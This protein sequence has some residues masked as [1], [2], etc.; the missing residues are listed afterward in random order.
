M[1]TN[2]KTRFRLALATLLLAPAVSY[3]QDVDIA[4][5]PALWVVESNDSRVYL[6]GS[7]HLLPP[8]VYPLPET[9]EAAYLR[10][11]AVAFEIDLSAANEMAMTMMQRGLFTDATTLADA[12]GAELAEEATAILMPMG[13]PGEA[14]ERMRPWMVA[15]IVGTSVAQLEGMEVAAGL[16]MHF[17]ERAGHDGKI[18]TS[19][20]TAESQIDIFA[21]MDE[22]AQAEYL[23]QAVDQMPE[24]GEKLRHMVAAW[25]IGDTEVLQALVQ[26]GMEQYP[27]LRTRLLEDRN[28]AWVPQ[29][30]AMLAEPGR[31]TLVVVG[32]A[33][34][35]GPHSVVEL[36]EEAGYEVR[37]L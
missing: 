15:M 19:F 1:S 12:V 14:V 26:E 9:V 32:A 21:S 23:R 28:R 31:T 33:H 27:A 10:S 25:R 7:V 29:I 11:D 34:L 4:T 16:D 8:D 6:L 22:Q 24:A 20:E 13:I 30:E 2:I 37:R 35:I 36:L 17:T 3:A 18:V 5:N